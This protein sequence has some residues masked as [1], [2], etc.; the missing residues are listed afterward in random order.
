MKELGFPPFPRVN[1]VASQIQNQNL[2][3]FEN[4]N[5]ASADYLECSSEFQ[6]YDDAM[7]PFDPSTNYLQL[8][9]ISISKCHINT[10]HGPLW[11][12][13]KNDPA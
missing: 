10:S 8:G 5:G 9:T 4:E 12:L 13:S 3:W 11:Q 6:A 7:T 1:I 2:K